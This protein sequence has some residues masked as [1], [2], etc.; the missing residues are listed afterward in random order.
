MLLVMMSVCQQCLRVVD[1][2]IGV[3]TV[4]RVVDNDVGL[5]TVLRVVDDDV[6]WC[7]SRV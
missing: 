4:L 6:S 7:E 2:D 1:D 5:S 3:S